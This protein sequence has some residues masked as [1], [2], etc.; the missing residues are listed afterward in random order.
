MA[1]DVAAGCVSRERATAVYGVALGAD[2]EADLAATEQLRA[3]LRGDA[4]R[5][6]L[7]DVSPSLAR[8][9]ESPHR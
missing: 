9:V 2:G 8:G 7:V 4:P 5:S 3:D 6:R 1:A